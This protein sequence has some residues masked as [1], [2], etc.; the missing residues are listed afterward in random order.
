MGRGLV[1]GHDFDFDRTCHT[2]NI[3]VTPTCSGYEKRGYT[4][5]PIWSQSKLMKGKPTRSAMHLAF[6]ALP[7]NAWLDYKGQSTNPE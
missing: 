4:F 7:K 6:L 2:S 1:V 5:R 3:P